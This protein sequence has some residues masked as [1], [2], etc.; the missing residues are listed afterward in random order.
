MAVGTMAWSLSVASIIGVGAAVI[1]GFL[2]LF[3]WRHREKRM[4][5]Q[6]S[7]QELNLA[8]WSLV[9]V[10][11]LG[12]G[13]L[14]EQLLWQRIT[15]GVAGFIPTVWL[16]FTFAYTSRDSWLTRSRVALLAVEPVVWFLVSLTNPIH[17]LA[18]TDAVLTATVFGPVTALEFGIAYAIHIAYA[19]A[20]VALGIGLLVLHATKIAPAYQ[21][22]VALL[23]V[24]VL[25]AL[26]SHALFTLG[27]SPI[28][29]LDLTPFVFAFTGVVFG[30]ALFE[31]N[32]LHLTPIARKQAF[33]EVGDGLL[34]VNKDDEI[35]DVI[36]VATSVLTPT[37]R[38]GDRLSDV[39]PKTTLEELDE[40]EISVSLDGK[41]RVYQFQVS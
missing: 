7:V 33:D 41:R 9:Y 20:L 10:V 22:Q 6:F 2:A 39:F 23:V 1:S 30:L 25:P 3:S 19:Y 35:I 13:T 34:I 28:P 5:L 15:L 21:K 37:P 16:L 29:G 11:Q 8:V 40:S 36:G 26:L 12:Y 38:I 18:W 31:F 14:G 17:G 24:G 32:L 4:A 27:L